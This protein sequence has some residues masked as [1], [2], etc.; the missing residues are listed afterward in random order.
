MTCWCR[1]RRPASSFRGRPSSSLDT[2]GYEEGARGVLC[3][4][5][6]APE[7]QDDPRGRAG[8]SHGSRRRPHAHSSGRPSEPPPRLRD[9]P[10]RSLRGSHGTRRAPQPPGGSHQLR[11]RDR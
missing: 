8:P 1:R 3:H 9:H 2:R 5:H 7:S 11:R 10:R 6:A 4:E